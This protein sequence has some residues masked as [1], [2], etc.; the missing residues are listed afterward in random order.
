[1]G[2]DLA[3]R[4][5]VCLSVN[6]LHEIYSETAGAT[7]V[8]VQ[9]VASFSVGIKVVAKGGAKS[10]LHGI[11]SYGAA[12]EKRIYCSSK[13]ISFLI[14]AEAQGMRSQNVRPKK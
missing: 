6:L 3:A 2:H 11:G 13:K 7:S 12:I 1:M 5:F 9:R 10:F 14:L 4:L 8:N